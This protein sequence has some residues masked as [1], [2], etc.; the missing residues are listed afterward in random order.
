MLEQCLGRARIA[1]QASVM[2]LDALAPRVVYFGDFV[3]LTVVARRGSR[4]GSRRGLQGRVSL[5]DRSS[6]RLGLVARRAVARTEAR[7][8]LPAIFTVVTARAGK[9]RV[10]RCA[11]DCRFGFF[12]AFV[13]LVRELARGLVE[14]DSLAGIEAGSR[15]GALGHDHLH[16]RKERGK[17]SHQPDG[18]RDYEKDSA[19]IQS[20][21]S[22]PLIFDDRFP[23]SLGA[24]AC[25]TDS[26]SSLNL[27]DDAVS[28]VTTE[29]PDYHGSVMAGRWWGIVMVS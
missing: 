15:I 27:R 6:A 23:R 9:E 5:S 24:T 11:I 8:H 2:E 22:S 21:H 14:H 28:S 13:E 17:K 18:Q 12:Q 4:R 7:Q 26:L 1:C 20:A 25:G 29:S 10:G 16:E 3:A 19:Q